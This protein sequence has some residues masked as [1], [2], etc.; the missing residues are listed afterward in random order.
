MVPEHPMAIK[1]ILLTLTSYPDPA[2]VPVIDGAVFTGARA[3]RPHRG[4]LVRGARLGR[5]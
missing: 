1:D 3:W 5:R 4:G 2:P